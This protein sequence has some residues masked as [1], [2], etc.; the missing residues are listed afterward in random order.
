MPLL[1]RVAEPFAL[2]MA[3]AWAAAADRWRALGCPYEAAAAL[4]DSPRSRSS[5][6]R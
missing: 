1:E 2:Q 3:G 4:A 6:R 5:A